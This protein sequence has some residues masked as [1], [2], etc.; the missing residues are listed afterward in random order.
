MKAVVITRKA[1]KQELKQAFKAQPEAMQKHEATTRNIAK[2]LASRL[3]LEDQDYAQ[4]VDR[5]YGE[6]QR[7][8][9]MHRDALRAAYIFSRRAPAEEREDLYQELTLRLLELRP[10]SERLAYAIARCDW[11]NWWRSYTLHGQ[12]DSTERLADAES[13]DDYGEDAIDRQVYHSALLVGECEHDARIDARTLYDGLP[14]HIQQ[15][16][17]RQLSG[18]RIAGGDRIMLRKWVASRPTVL[19]SYV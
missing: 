6:L 5:I 3:G 18:H 13:G 10:N 9:Q 19:A 17:T 7:L 2:M 15:I 1:T 4:A 14:R 12:Y 8:P 16:V 11:Q